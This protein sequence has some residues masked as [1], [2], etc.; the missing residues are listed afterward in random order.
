MF[1]IILLSMKE[2]NIIPIFNNKEADIVQDF[3][4]IKTATMTAEHR[5]ATSRA[6]IRT[7]VEEHINARCPQFAFGAYVGD[8]MVGFIHGKAHGRFATI[9]SLYV[10]PKWQG[11]GLGRRLLNNMERAMSLSCSEIEL[12]SLAGAMD[13]YRRHGYGT[14][15]G[16][17]VYVKSRLTLP[18]CE[19]VPVFRCPKVL[20]D[21]FQQ[22]NPKF[23][24]AYVNVQHQPLFAYYNV[25]NKVVGY[26]TTDKIF[27][28]PWY[29]GTSVVNASL[30]HKMEN[31][32]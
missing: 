12:V 9:Q 27:V 10:L 11:K 30:R 28:Q 22:L 23:D 6:E 20:A 24:A 4:R 15:F 17:S 13:F 25:D 19:S 3:V 16:S 26:A 21:K 8:K 18:S 29:W 31:H 32:R 1:C 2:V 14:P 7:Q 5:R